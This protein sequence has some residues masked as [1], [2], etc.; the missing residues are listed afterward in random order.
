MLALV[1]SPVKRSRS[2]EQRQ[3]QG[4]CRD[5]MLRTSGQAA[6]GE[7]ARLLLLQYM[8]LGVL[9]ERRQKDRAKGQGSQSWCSHVDQPTST[10]TSG[11]LGELIT[12]LMVT[13]IFEKAWLT[14]QKD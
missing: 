6:P 2:T 9:L 1:K 14:Q 10:R 5:K 11:M 4:L 12:R 7:E 8:Y 13:I 3:L